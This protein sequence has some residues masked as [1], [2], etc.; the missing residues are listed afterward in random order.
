MNE[1]DELVIYRLER[2]NSTLDDAR[3]LLD[4]GK[5]NSAINRLYY[6]CFYAVLALLQTKNLSSSKHMGVLSLFSKE[7]V[8]TGIIPK[9]QGRF[10]RKLFEYRQEG[11]YVDF[12]EFTQ[13]VGEKLYHNTQGFIREI[14]KIIEGDKT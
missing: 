12:T 13:T 6:A 14:R 5:L 9:E 2:A 1:T 3:L 7:F 4:K 11:D 8:K 10:Y